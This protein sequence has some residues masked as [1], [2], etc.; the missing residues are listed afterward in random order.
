MSTRFPLFFCLALLALAALPAAAQ[1]PVVTVNGPTAV[2][3]ARN[4]YTVTWE[5][6]ASGGS[7]PYTYS[8]TLDGS[9]IGT[10]SPTVTKQYCSTSG[11]CSVF[12][13]TIQVLLTDLNG[14]EDTDSLTITV[15]L[16]G[17]NSS[18]TSC[19]C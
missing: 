13:D 8:W 16:R 14:R 12:N 11:T 7:T 6:V 17:C 9:A 18:G 2:T 3:V 1:S 15:T 19:A 10:N 5:A 4:C